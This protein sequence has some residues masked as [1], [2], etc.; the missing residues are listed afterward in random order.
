MSRAMAD[1]PIPPA[2]AIIERAPIHALA[3]ALS[4]RWGLVAVDDAPYR[5]SC[6]R[7][8]GRDYLGP[9]GEVLSSWEWACFRCRAA[10]TIWELRRLVLED[11]GAVHRVMSGG[12]D[13][14]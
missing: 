2:W 12:Q 8:G 13:D 14:S 7:C 10:G 1:E 5:F 11:L 4:P 3:R 9:T 6:P